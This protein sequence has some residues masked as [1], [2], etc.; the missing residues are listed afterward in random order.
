M[1]QVDC[2]YRHPQRDF[3]QSD[4]AFRLRSVGEQ[5]MMTYK[6]PKLDQTT[7]TRCEEEVRLADGETARQSCAA[8]LSHLGFEPVATVTKHRVIG[9]FERE[10][11]AVEVA[12]DQIEEL[13][14]FVET[15][16]GFQGD[17]AGLDAAR[18]ILAQLAS[19]LGLS[20][21]ERRSYLELLLASSK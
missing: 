17:S 12:L 20:D 3:A 4:E 9:Q 1:K 8:I 5:N 11:F 19:E 7:K 14:L 18:E 10:G 21:V 2:Y 13:G 16:I 6:G 15:E